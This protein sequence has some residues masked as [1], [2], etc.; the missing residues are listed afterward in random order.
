[1]SDYENLKFN[2]FSHNSILL[3]NLSDPDLNFTSEEHFN[4]ETNYY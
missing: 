1:M 4:L 3:D 2:P